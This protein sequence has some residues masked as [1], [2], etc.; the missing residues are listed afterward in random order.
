MFNPVKAHRTARVLR[1]HA[2][3]LDFLTRAAFASQR[4][5]PQGSRRQQLLHHAIQHW[6]RTAS[7]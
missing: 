5:L 4:W 6:Y 2:N 7:V 3:L 1:R